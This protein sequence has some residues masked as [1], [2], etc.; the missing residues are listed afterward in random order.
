MAVCYLLAA[1]PS[2]TPLTSEGE[3]ESHGASQLKETFGGYDCEFAELPP[4]YL[5][6]DCP[7]CRM[8]LRDPHQCKCCGVNFCCS[9][10]KQVQAERNS[11][12]I[13]RKD[14]FEV[15]EDEDL[16]QVLIQLR[17][18][19]SKDGCKWKGELGELKHHLSEVTHPG[20]LVG[21][22][23]SDVIEK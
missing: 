23:I 13:C 10:I 3:V 15:F 20:K 17:V 19:C 5:Q 7:I 8:I 14:S 6:T 4:S 12:P 2:N 22:H 21:S 9:C 11:C 18:L 1:P 16:K